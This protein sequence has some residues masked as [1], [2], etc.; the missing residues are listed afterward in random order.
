MDVWPVLGDLG[1]LVDTDSGPPLEFFTHRALGV[2]FTVVRGGKCGAP[3]HVSCARNLNALGI[4]V[5]AD[6]PERRRNVER[7]LDHPGDHPQKPAGRTP[8]NTVA[9]DRLS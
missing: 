7:S 2:G 4:Q 5:L 3:D 1:Q 9:S 8:L 6:D